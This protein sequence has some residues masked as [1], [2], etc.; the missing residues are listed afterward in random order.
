MQLTRLDPPSFM[1]DKVVYV[2]T[3][4]YTPCITER[5]V[6]GGRI[7]LVGVAHCFL[8]HPVARWSSTLTHVSECMLVQ[9]GFAPCI[10]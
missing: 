2:Y 5:Q 10:S 7:P 4:T 3:Q 9:N 8:R 6:I 1:Y